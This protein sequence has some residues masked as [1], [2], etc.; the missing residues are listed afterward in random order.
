MK[1]NG[2]QKSLNTKLKDSSSKLIFQDPILC[3]QF[4][5]DY[6]DIPLLKDVQPED[7]EDET[8][9]FV[10]LF[11]EERNSDVVKRVRL[12]K[13]KTS[14]YLISLIEHKSEVDYNVVMQIFRYMAFIWE[15]YEK[16]QNRKYKGISKTKNFKYPP[17]LPIVY[18]EG[19]GNWT[20]V[21][22]LHDRVYLSD[23]LGEFIPDYRCIMVQLNE[24]TNQNL[25]EKAD[26]LSIIMMLN[27]LQERED[28]ASLKEEVPIEYLKK[29][30]SGTPEYLLGIMVQVTE[31]LLRR[32][33][34]PQ[35]EA[36]E[37][38]EQV[39]E[40][41]MG[42]LFAILEENL[43]RDRQEL[44]EEGY[45]A[46]ILDYIEEGISEDRLLQKLQKRFKLSEEKAKYYYDKFSSRAQVDSTSQTAE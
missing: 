10:H 36:E 40:H 30:T 16:E 45:E 17:I 25:M 31:I 8:E 38:A 43:Q 33:N 29:V 34:V 41:K 22:R 13:G 3:A 39:K 24:Y 9:R 21:T 15:D 1:Q 18:Y 4:L 44:R 2:K 37:F 12:N 32:L 5:R 27:K 19:E 28:F 23:E 42:E 6:V 7:I 46:F 14:F 11:T 26:E 35:E 20:A